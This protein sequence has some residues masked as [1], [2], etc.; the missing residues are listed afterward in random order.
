M[1]LLPETTSDC[2]EVFCRAVRQATGQ[3]RIGVVLDGSGSHRSEQFQ[4]PRALVPLRLPAY[5]PEL[6]PAEQLFRH[7]RKQLANRLFHLCERVGRSA[8]PGASP[9]AARPSWHSAVHVLSLAEQGRE[10]P[11]MIS[12]KEYRTL[13]SRSFIRKPL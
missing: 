2:L 6:N 8:Q 12:V 13:P 4:W 3:Q 5:S 7:L 9:M 10:Y 1:L 11:I